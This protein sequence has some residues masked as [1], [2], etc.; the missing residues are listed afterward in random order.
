MIPAWTPAL[1]WIATGGT[2]AALCGLAAH[3]ALAGAAETPAVHIAPSGCSDAADGSP[4]H[5][6]CTLQAALKRGKPAVLAAGGTYRLQSVVAANPSTMTW[7]GPVDGA[8]ARF[9]DLRLVGSS[10]IGF[11]GL[12]LGTVRTTTS[13]HVAWIANDVTAGYG[14]FSLSSHHLRYERNRIHDTDDGIINTTT[15][16]VDIVDNEFFR[17]P[18]PRRASG[19]DGIQPG[20]VARMRIVGNRFRDFRGI[21]HNDG[22]EASYANTDLDIRQNTFSNVRP[23]IIIPGHHSNTYVNRRIVFADNLVRGGGDWCLQTVNLQQAYVFNNTCVDTPT[24]LRFHG[25]LAKDNLVANNVTDA[26][27]IDRPVM[28]REV[29]NLTRRLLAYGRSGPLPGAGTL[30][31]TTAAFS[32]DFRLLPGSAGT[33]RGIPVVLPPAFRPAA[34][35]S[36]ADA[37]TAS[38]WAEVADR[39]GGLDLGYRPAVG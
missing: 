6:L 34:S 3:P 23:V 12:S 24:G 9:P 2:A 39:A 7:V 21:P 35:A 25:G 20:K 11:T 31:G 36:A 13:H 10:N 5:P 38:F 14:M 33:R 15:T 4:E 32:A 30:L 27:E 37:L 28:A 16:D 19:G 22:I 1:R 29:S 8:T 17:L 26:I 18:T